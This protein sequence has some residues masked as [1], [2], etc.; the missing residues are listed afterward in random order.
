MRNKFIIAIIA[1]CFINCKKDKQ[2]TPS[3][4]T[5]IKKYNLVCV[6]NNLIYDGWITKRLLETLNILEWDIYNKGEYN[7]TTTKMLL[8]NNISKI[9]SQRKKDK[10]NVLLVNEIIFDLQKV[11][12][13]QAYNN[14][15]KYCKIMK[16]SGYVVI[17]TTATPTNNTIMFP[18]DFEYN[19]LKVNDSLK[20]ANNSFSFLADVSRDEH[21]GLNANDTTYFR[22][23]YL[24]TSKG[25]YI[26]VDS[27][28]KPI[29]LK[30]N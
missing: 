26:F 28:I 14:I 13:I 23:G 19:R 24:M 25:Y 11:N 3:T 27:Y 22:N 8:P 4:S 5:D 10:I 20:I 17:L 6:G 16:D 30:I 9:L 29:L 21:I 1:L 15:T 7:N 18:M 12:Y 2:A